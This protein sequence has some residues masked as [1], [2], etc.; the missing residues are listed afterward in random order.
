MTTCVR[1]CFSILFLGNCLSHVFLEKFLRGQTSCYQLL[2]DCARCLCVQLLTSYARFCQEQRTLVV[3][4][5]CYYQMLEKLRTD[6]TF[7]VFPRGQSASTMVKEFFVTEKKY[8][9]IAVI[10]SE[11]EI[12]HGNIAWHGRNNVDEAGFYCK[13][14]EPEAESPKKKPKVEQVRFTWMHN[15]KNG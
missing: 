8:A 7:L 4:Y 11:M 1:L 9:D 12:K 5:A 15:F 10:T 6:P 14:E 13:D 3:A 2:P